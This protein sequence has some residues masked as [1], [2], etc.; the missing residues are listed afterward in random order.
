MRLSVLTLLAFSFAPGLARGDDKKEP[1]AKVSPGDLARDPAKYA[2]QTVQVEGVV[3]E[4]PTA[5]G[6]AVTLWL[7][8][9][10]FPIACDGKPD[11]VAGDRVFVTAVCEYAGKPPKLTLRDAVVEKLA[12]KEPPIPLTFEELF[13]EPKKYDGK[14][15]AV[16]GV[17]RNTPEAVE[18]LGEFRYQPRLVAGLAI[19]C[20][21][22]PTAIKGQRVRI[23]GTLTCTDNTFAPLTLDATLVQVVPR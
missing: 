6:R 10:D 3:A 11:V 17:L 4:T 15:I 20:H 23:S 7:E 16:E 5:K 19:T 8:R 21:G 1:P 12:A 18:F 14:L 13:K 22:K 2:G 9:A